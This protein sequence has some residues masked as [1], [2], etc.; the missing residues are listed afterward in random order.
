M[1]SFKL[2]IVL[3]VAENDPNYRDVAQ[4]FKPKPMAKF[5]LSYSR[6]D[7]QRKKGYSFGQTIS[8]NTIIVIDDLSKQI[9][10]C[11]QKLLPLVLKH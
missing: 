11:W 9:L 7:G 6:H 2:N 4:S 10:A 5:S 3:H 8:E 1:I